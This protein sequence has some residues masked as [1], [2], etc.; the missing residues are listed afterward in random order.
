[1]GIV[2]RR[3]TLRGESGPKDVKIEGDRIVEIGDRIHGSAEREIDATGRLV[4]PGLV[5]PHLHLDKVLTGHLVNPSNTLEEALKANRDYLTKY[6]VDEVKNRVRGVL[7]SAILHGTTALRAF[8]DVDKAC[9]V[10]AVQA[11]LDMKREYREAIDLQITPFVY[12]YRV[13]GN[14]ELLIKAAE[15]GSDVIG[16][17]VF[18]LDNGMS[19]EECKDYVDRTFSIAKRFDLDVHMLVDDQEDPNSHLL[20]YYA[21][22]T[23]REGF[24]GRT[25]ASHAEGLSVV[26]DIYASKVISLVKSAG[27]SICANG[28]VNLGRDDIVLSRGNTRVREFMEAGVNVTS[29]QD[30]VD[31]FYYPFGIPDMLEIAFMASHLARLIT[32]EGLEIALDMVTINGAKALRLKDYGLRVGAKADLVVLNAPTVRD[33]LRLRPDRVVIKNGRVVAES[34]MEQKLF[35]R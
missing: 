21:I 10:S 6:S 19:E 29:G 14:E 31:D 20:E 11:M 34:R 8:V 22:K 33:A 12:D 3:A 13:K 25:T 4:T 5:N 2:I 16:G 15:M 18:L 23:I 30:D 1:M 35:L 32:P 7:E 27:M 26:N 17:V 24:Q 9:G 28:H